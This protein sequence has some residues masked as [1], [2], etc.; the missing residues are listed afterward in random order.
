MKEA[1][2][3]CKDIVDPSDP[4]FQ[5]SNMY[6][7][8]QAA[9]MAKE[10]YK[11]DE[12]AVVTALIHDVGKIILHKDFGNEPAWNVMGDTFVVGHP[13]PSCAIFPEFHSLNKDA[14]LGTSYYMN[15]GI[16]NLQCSFGHDEYLYM[17]LKHNAVKHLLDEKYWN[18]I[19]YHSL[20]PW[21]NGN[22]YRDFMV[23]TDYEILEDVKK[24]QKCDLYSKKGL[25][26]WKPTTEFME[27]CDDL[28]QTYFPTP[29][30]F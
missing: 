3:I 13:I 27:Y 24:F 30:N 23:E 20:Y 11:G 2:D 9:E 16:N 17:V 8:Y 18:I 1:L 7:N 5:E 6:H 29:L 10:V 22:A 14:Q 19:R 4:D 15:S 12:K 26:V 28:L 21:H 25:E